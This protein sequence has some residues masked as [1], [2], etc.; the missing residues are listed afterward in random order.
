MIFIGKSPYRVSLLG[1]GSDLDW[2]VKEKGFGI[3]L[4]FSLNQYSYSVINVLPEN[5]KSGMLEYSTREIYSNINDI[6]HPIVRE[7][8]NEMKVPRYI[9]LKTFG[10]ASGGSGLGGSA[11][12]ILSLL[13]ALSNAF[14]INL[15]NSDLI[16]KAC[17]IEINKLKKPI[18]KQDH[19]LCANEGF[20]SFTFFD[21]GN[22]KQNKLSKQKLKTLE[23][24]AEHFYLIPT[25]KN[26][27]AEI[28]LSGIKGDTKSLDKILEIRR[29][30]SNFLSFEDQ[31][32]F[33]IEELF[34]KSVNE[35]WEI[36][37]SMSQVMTPFLIEQY[38]NIKTLIPNNWIRLI[39]AGNGGYFLISSKINQ[40]EINNIS[41]EI[42]VKGI[43]KATPSKEGVS[44][45]KV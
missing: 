43:F 8:L 33:K 23:R 35:S 44:G 5:S 28:I 39:G 6:V 3:C 9:E 14:G 31:R 18:G 24:L 12:F 27:N 7:V 25:N 32:D 20:N 30:A 29:I 41:N 37:K 45:F 19:Y 21:N 42:G 1:G 17:F 34:H 2:F 16:D 4:G 11:S 40:S 38:E 15:N 22:V 36:K 13:N 10:F 26:R